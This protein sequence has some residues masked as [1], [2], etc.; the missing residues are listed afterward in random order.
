MARGAGAHPAALGACPGHRMEVREAAQR[1]LRRAGRVVHRRRDELAHRTVREEVA[2]MEIGETMREYTIE[3]VEDPFQ[4]EVP[5]EAPA[6][7]EPLLV[8]AEDSELV[9]A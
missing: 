8:P 6:R 1:G 5:D 7:P 9:P 4:R 2:V 3:P